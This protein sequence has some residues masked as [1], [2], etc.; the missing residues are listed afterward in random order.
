[1]TALEYLK[2]LPR[3]WLPGNT[4]GTGR[5]SNSELVRWLNQGAIVINHRT[6]A[7]DKVMFPIKELI[8][9]PHGKRRTTLIKEE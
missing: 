4:I 7:R 8:F 3:T 9:F 1:M 6:R 2:S 5:A